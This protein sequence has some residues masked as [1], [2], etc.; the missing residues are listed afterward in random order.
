MSYWQD[1]QLQIKKTQ[2]SKAKKYEIEYQRRL[3]QT[4]KEIEQEINKWCAKYAKED[5]TIDSLQAKKL[6][7]GSELQNFKY[8]LKEW[9]KMAND[10]GYTHE[11]NLEYYKSKVSRLRSLEGQ[12]ATI[13][14]EQTKTDEPALAKLMK[15][16]YKDTYYR[17]IYNT[18]MQQAKISG[19][20]ARVSENKLEAIIRSGWRGANFSERIWGNSVKQ[21]PKVLSESLFR[22]I[23]LGY[24]QDRLIKMARVN[25]QNF[26][27]GQIHRLV[28]TETA[29]ITEQATLS[30]YEASGVEKY[31]YLATLERHTCE[32]CRKLDGKV[33]DVKKQLAGENYPPIHPYCRCT[34]A[35]WDEWLSKLKNPT[36][37]ARD[38]QTG[39]GV[40]TTGTS[41]KEWVKMVGIAS[42]ESSSGN[43]MKP[44]EEKQTFKF[45][46]WTLENWEDEERIKE[47]VSTL[48][49]NLALYKEETGVDVVEAFKNDVFTYGRLHRGEEN[50]TTPYT[51][52]HQNYTRW[53]LKRTGYD[54][55]PQEI[56]NTNGLE[57][58][59]RG[60]VDWEEGNTSGA[61]FANRYKSGEFDISGATSS[62]YGR[63]AYFGDKEIAAEYASDGE[64]GVVFS[65][66]AMP[67]MK[68]L[69][70]SVLSYMRWKVKNKYSDKRVNQMSD[71][72]AIEKMLIDGWSMDNNDDLFSIINGYDAM[73]TPEGYLI[74]FNR[75]KTG[76]ER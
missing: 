19:N 27:K 70:N 66:Y 2:L 23:A 32:V 73:E 20:F 28:I 17:T 46:E 15:D 55:L 42:N 64:N 51:D 56:S 72:E 76:V 6:L 9:E 44:K 75:T 71:D 13:M 29:H 16:T 57:K 69:D 49:E 31:E 34:T 35:P 12:V 48:K 36:R 8:T 5:G 63:G 10:G 41:Y 18:Q 61:E 30:A 74:V 43:I 53:L 59:Y 60:V 58:Y 21:L 25:L 24:G 38:P 7:R 1:R 4:Q 65:V 62:Q 26:S 39:K 50:G 11:M 54:G 68:V 45:R 40:S 47:A 67:N 14:A 33:I 37:W 52:V 3:K 22:G